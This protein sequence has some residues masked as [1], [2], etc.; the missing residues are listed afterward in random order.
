MLPFFLIPLHEMLMDS[1]LAQLKATYQLKELVESSSY[2][3]FV[4]LAKDFTERCM[5]STKEIGQ[6]QVFLFQ[7]GTFCF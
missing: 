5:T 4:Q 7:S 6:E 2:D 1:K 3:L